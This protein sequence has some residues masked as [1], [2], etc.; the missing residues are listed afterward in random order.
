MSKYRILKFHSANY[1]N[2]FEEFAAKKGTLTGVGTPPPLPRQ[3]QTHPRS[4]SSQSPLSP[5]I[6]CSGGH[7]LSPPFVS[8]ISVTSTSPMREARSAVV[9]ARCGKKLEFGMRE[10]RRWEKKP[11]LGA[12]R[13]RLDW[14]ASD[15]HPPKTTPLPRPRL[16]G[17]AHEASPS[18][19][20]L[21]RSS[22]LV[23]T[24]SNTRGGQLISPAP[25][26]VVLYTRLTH[27]RSCLH[28]LPS[29]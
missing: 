27:V 25:G 10:V 14:T 8:S 22:P 28:M 2:A 29:L 13:D 16:N 4:S 7:V 20:P 11:R 26:T 15:L 17:C 24:T 5:K 3:W 9:A 19:S 23:R 1:E 12:H 18:P 6:W 21:T